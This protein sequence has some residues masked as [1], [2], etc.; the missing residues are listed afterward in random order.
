M[1][2]HTPHGEEPYTLSSAVGWLNPIQTLRS[3]G[4]RNRAQHWFPAETPS[5][6]A[7]CHSLVSCNSQNTSHYDHMITWGCGKPDPTLPWAGK[8][9]DTQQDPTH[10]LIWTLQVNGRDLR[11]AGFQWCLE[12]MK[13]L[14]IFQGFEPLAPRILATHSNALVGRQA[15]T[16]GCWCRTVFTSNSRSYCAGCQQYSLLV[17]A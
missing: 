1:Q 5:W 6:K 10:T 4:P 8:S 16:W 12:K 11:W 3:G 13:G 9:R 15:S 17:M 2:Q 14:A 7:V